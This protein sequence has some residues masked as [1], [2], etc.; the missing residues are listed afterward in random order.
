M[1]RMQWDPSSV[2][3]YL[4]QPNPQNGYIKTGYNF[5]GGFAY[6]PGNGGTLLT[7]AMMA[8]GT[9]SSPLMSFPASWGA[10]AEGFLTTYP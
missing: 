10:A 5:Q 2:V 9:D 4:L 8:G 7:V 6:L 3:D 1:A